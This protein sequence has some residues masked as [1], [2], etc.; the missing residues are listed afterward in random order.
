[1]LFIGTPGTEIIPNTTFTGTSSVPDSNIP[2]IYNIY[3]PYGN[4]SATLSLVA[5]QTYPMLINFSQTQGGYVLGFS[6]QSPNSTTTITDF[7]GYIVPTLPNISCFKEGTKILTLDGYQKIEDLKSGDLIKTKNNSFVPIYQ[8]GYRKI[9]HPATNKRI[10]NQLYYCSPR[11]YLDLFEPLVITGCHSIL[12]DEFDSVYEKEQS[13]II[14]EQIYITDNKYR[15]PVCVDKRSKIYET[16]GEY[17]IYHIS[18]ENDDYYMNYG[19]Y[20]NG[21]LVESCSKKNLSE[22][23]EMTIKQ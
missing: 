11:D 5:G 13:I 6:F 21:L 22:L 10:K 14:N 15:V 12:V 4:Y 7:T 16:P 2:V 9:F 17:M 19:I 3:W 8:I 23:S 1:M 18:L 20:A